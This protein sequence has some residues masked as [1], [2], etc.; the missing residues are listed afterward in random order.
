MP[1]TIADLPIER[2]ERLERA[3]LGDPEVGH[4]G[5]IERLNAYEQ[6]HRDMEQSRIDGDRR[7]H[8]R[9]D[10]HIEEIGQIVKATEL[11]VEENERQAAAHRN[12]IEKKIDR[13]WWMLIG[14]TGAG[15]AIGWGISG[16]P[17]LGG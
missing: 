3:I 9:L 15:V 1:G 14:S 12:K 17:P 10:A 13:L 7:L 4:L 5:A 8:Q 6:R 16:A 11:E 2:F